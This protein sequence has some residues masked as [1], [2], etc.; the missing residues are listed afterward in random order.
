MANTLSKH[1]VLGKS[2]YTPYCSTSLN[3]TESLLFVY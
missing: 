3:L 1:W 2:Q